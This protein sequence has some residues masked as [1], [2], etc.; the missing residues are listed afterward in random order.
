MVLMKNGIPC[1]P[2]PISPTKAA[3]WSWAVAA[4]SGRAHPLLIATVLTTP[5]C[6][7]PAHATPFYCT[8][9]NVRASQ[10][11]TPDLR[12]E[13]GASE[14]DNAPRKATSW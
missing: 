14:S 3:G 13:V 8:W 6:V 10:F 2:G 1:H 7:H 5:N 9:Q 12:D 11:V 4:L